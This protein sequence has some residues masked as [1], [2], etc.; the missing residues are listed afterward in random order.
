[1]NVR[2]ADIGF[3]WKLSDIAKAKGPKYV[4]T[5]AC[6]G[7]SSM[8][9]SLAG[10]QRVG[11]LEIDKRMLD[12]FTI[13]LG[14][15]D[16]VNRDIR[17]V[18]NDP[19]LIPRS[20]FGI[21]VIDG[22]PPCTVFSSARPSGKRSAERLYAE[23]AIRQRLDDLFS[24]FL[25]FVEIVSPSAFVAENVVGLS[26][27]ANRGY[28]QDIL[29]M[30]EKIGYNLQVFKL[31][32]ASH[33]LPQ[34]R[35]RLFFI[36]TKTERK[37]P[38]FLKRQTNTVGKALSSVR[39]CRG[40]LKHLTGSLL[41]NYHQTKPGHRVKTGGFT[42]V[43]LNENAIASALCA[44]RIGP[45]HWK[46]PRF[47]TYDEC[48]RMQSFPDDYEFNGQCGQYVCGMSVPPLEEKREP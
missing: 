31:N 29:K 1:M 18:V 26:S 13:N 3:D 6:G 5:F 28:F 48:A 14:K 7:G 10:W 20:W 43:R 9:Y 37:I 41:A 24:W 34:L 27:P 46:Q 40:G 21:D 33:G 2:A 30:T 36:G 32:A 45:V 22:S 42:C 8:G 25:R 11:V 12:C 15:R 44:C 4:S 47:L 39:S 17:D 35:K 23:G 38:S 16:D 19:S